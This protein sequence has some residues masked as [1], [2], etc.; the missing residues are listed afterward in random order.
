MASDA[1]PWR[2]RLF[3][4]TQQ[5]C[6]HSVGIWLMWP[7]A[8]AWLKVVRGYRIHDLEGVRRKFR[9]LVAQT[10]GPLLLCCNHLTWIDS[11]LVQWAL[12]SSAT[13]SRA[14][15]LFLWNLPEKTNFYRNLGLRTIC[16]LG[17]CLPITRGGDREQQ[18]RVLDK[19]RHLLESRELVLAFPEGGRSRTGRFDAERV[20]YGV[21]RFVHDAPDCSVLCLYLRGDK[22]EQMS[23][24]PNRGE[25]FS[26]DLRLIQ[27]RSTSRGLRAHRD[28]SR[29]IVATLSEMEQ[30]YFA[31]R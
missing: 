13:A 2:D 23:V 17:K 16:Y 20:T 5:R 4:D 26:L 28:I 19:V 25:S 3:L 29:Q 15:R 9:R 27:P 18:K 31:N 21:G 24:L 8:E 1:L 11:V 7:M 10:S 30:E 22:Q 12:V 14:T 6:A